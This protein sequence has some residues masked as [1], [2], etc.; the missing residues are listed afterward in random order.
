MVDNDEYGREGVSSADIELIRSYGAAHD[1]EWVDVW[2][3]RNPQ[4]VLVALL[5]DEDLSE[6]ERALRQ[7]VSRPDRL[8]VR[9][10][11]WPRH[12]LE[13][14]QEELME[15][16]RSAGNH[17]I[18]FQTLGIGKGIVNVHL[19]AD[20]KVFALQLEMKYGDA[21][22]VI[23]GNFHFPDVGPT[24]HSP[25]TTGPSVDA[26]SFDALPSTIVVTIDDEIRV[27]SGRSRGSA[28]RVNNLGND[29]LVLDT[30]GGGT[31]TVGA[32]ATSEVVGG[33]S[34]AK[35]APL[36]KFRVPAGLS[37]L[38]PMLVGTTASKPELGYCVPVGS[39]ALVVRLKFEDVGEFLTAPLPLKV[40][41]RE[42]SRD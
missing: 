3:E 40:I 23:V 36:V 29:D 21:I 28:I 18:P 34:G 27:E 10:A 13:K 38:I 2:G 15:L 22:D 33:W 17:G 6:H 41:A 1:Q 4:F 19:N 26:P 42:A 11:A 20:Q 7:L 37:A 14:V 31:A 9:R 32:P 8:E 39:W 5:W 12:H 24:I 30:K 25:R 35:T 16:W